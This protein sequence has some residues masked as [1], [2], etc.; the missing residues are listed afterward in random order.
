M[1]HLPG[2]K[3]Y[4]RLPLS[5]S[6][7]D[8]DVDSELRFHLE[9][10]EDALVARGLDRTA[11]RA[12]ALRQF[13]DLDRFRRECRELTKGRARAERRAELLDSV[14]QDLAYAVRSLRRAPGFAAVA[15]ST[16]ALGI[17]ATTA[18]FSV[19]SAVLLRPLPYYEA[20]RIVLLG[21]RPRSENRTVTT[22]SFPNFEEWQARAESFESMAVYHKWEPALTGTGEPERLDAAL[23]TAGVFD[24]LRVHP[25]LGRPLVPRENDPHAAPVAVVSYGFWRSRLAGNPGV[26]GR[27][28]TLN[29][30]PRTI[31]GVLPPGFKAPGELDADLW[32]NDYRDP[33]DG[34]SSRYL[35]VIA[36]LAHGVTLERARAEMGAIA[37]RMEA[38]YPDDNEGLTVAVTPLRERLVGDTRT[39]LLVLLSASGLVLVIACA[40]LSNL[41][42]ARGIARARE[43]AVRAALGAS[44]GRAV[45][46]LLTESMLLAA[47]GSAAGLLLAAWATKVL[48]AM[49]PESVRAQEIGVDGRVLG[50]TLLLTL[51][52]GLV[53]G[54]LPALKTTQV[55]VQHTL[56]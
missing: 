37:A 52:T 43:F 18:I 10:K 42:I 33:Q 24:V 1:P 32:A 28:L 26:I 17:G 34:R 21:E 54:L 47:L 44:R 22:T 39:P 56:K 23:V 7:A 29:G 50:F 31:V 38:E 45:R 3:R 5:E 11:A 27:S 2:I 41:L 19:V 6:R 35:Q 16:L 9:L 53:F 49:G 15:I 25:L 8:E 30:I 13:G 55:D 14:R 20:D 46:Q 12:E 51:L 36:R 4:F 48:V 40:N